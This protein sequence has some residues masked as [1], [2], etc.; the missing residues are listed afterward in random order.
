[1]PRTKLPR[2]KRK[3]KKRK[4]KKRKRESNKPLSFWAKDERLSHKFHSGKV[5]VLFLHFL[6][7]L[8]REEKKMRGKK[9]K[10]KKKKK[11]NKKKKRN[12]RDIQTRSR[13]AL[14]R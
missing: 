6:D 10:K 11:K 3:E 2:K 8:F 14:P 5:L 4:E 9:K 12:E 13:A 7:G 1:M